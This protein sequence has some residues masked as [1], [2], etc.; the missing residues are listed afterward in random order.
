MSESLPQIFRVQKMDSVEKDIFLINPIIYLLDVN[1]PF[2]PHLF[3]LNK[4]T[5][6]DTTLSYQFD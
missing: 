2:I 1:I 4:T 6:T 3:Y 5:D